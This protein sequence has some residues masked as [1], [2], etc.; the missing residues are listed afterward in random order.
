MSM[1]NTNSKGKKGR[2]GRRGQGEELQINILKKECVAFALKIMRDEIDVN[3]Q[4][5]IR[6]TEKVL[7]RAIP[8]E[9]IVQGDSTK[10]ITI[11]IVNYQ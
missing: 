5:K 1:R 9:N 3:L 6:I 11:K 2:S 7:T 8:Q 4:D 10:P